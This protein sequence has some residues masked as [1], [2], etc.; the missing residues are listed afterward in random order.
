MLFYSY[1]FLL[2]MLTF[3]VANYNALFFATHGP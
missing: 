3:F 2:T 1:I